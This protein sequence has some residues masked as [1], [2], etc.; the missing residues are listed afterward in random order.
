MAAK[1]IPSFSNE[2]PSETI[3]LWQRDSKGRFCNLASG[4]INKSA[5]V[6]ASGGILA[7][8][9]GLGK[10]LQI[11]SLILTGGRGTTLIV[12]PVSVMSNWEQQIRQHVLP[13]HMPS[14]FI[15]H[16]GN[17]EARNIKTKD[18]LKYDVVI[19]SYGKLARESGAGQGLSNPSIQWRR[20]VLDEGH[21]IRN[22]RTQVAIA[23]CA[24]H[25]QSR[26]VLTGTPII[27]S[28]KDLQ[29]LVRFLHLTG[30]IEQPD[31]F[32]VAVA[33]RLGKGGSGVGD[34]LLVALLRDI[35][36]R[37]KKDMSFIDLKLPE[38]KE[39]IHRIAFRPDE[40]HKYDALLAEARGA[41]EKYQAK[42]AKTATQGLFQSVLERLLRLRQTS[43][44]LLLL[45]VLA[46][47][48]IDAITGPSVGKE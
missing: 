12:A 34:Q 44:H 40:K 27:N 14:V 1:E 20:I 13:E 38:K 15:Y 17:P 8:D 9:M 41:L 28:V 23:A 43:D 39:F 48:P 32:N 29:S 24:I 45:I 3:Q 30:G 22:A 33:R 5:P 31:V 35:C 16:S 25:A 47:F 18:L 10:T 4:F 42:S 2:K 36:L 7:D 19:T 11:I 46:D 21:T 37:R 6:L 26:W